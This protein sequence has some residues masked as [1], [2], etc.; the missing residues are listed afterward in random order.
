MA[1]LGAYYIDSDSFTTATAVYTNA[2]LT[3]AAA[4]GFY[5]NCGVYRQQ[6]SGVLGPVITCPNCTGATCGTL[7]S[8]GWTTTEQG[9]YQFDIQLSAAVGAWRLALT[10]GVLPGK[11]RV[12]FPAS[13]GTFYTGGSSSNFGYLAG[14]YFGDTTTATTYNFPG[15]SPYIV[16]DFE[17]AG[18]SA[19]TSFAPTGTSQSVAIA[20]GDFS[21]TA[22]APG[23]VVMFIP[24]TLADLQNA[25]VTVTGPI[26]GASD[27]FSLTNSC[28][29]T[30]TSVLCTTNQASAV[31]ACGAAITTSYFNGPVTGSAGTPGIYDF[32][33]TNNNS[34]TTLA[35]VGGAGFYGYRTT[36]G[37]TPTGYFQLDANSVIVAIG[38]CPP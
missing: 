35:S 6:T 38:T 36:P 27:S 13:S 37:A 22:G 30:L 31:A 14:P 20:P 32:M 1:T 33:Y 9:I 23:N 26:G 3:T 7:P 12:E 2:N 19:G 18:D 29:S 34:S 15:L 8:G 25:T 24:K 28:A 10:P 16:S 17:W 4:D 5:Q 21:G 11:I